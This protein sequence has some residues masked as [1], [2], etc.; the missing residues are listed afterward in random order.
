MAAAQKVMII[1]S[2]GYAVGVTSQGELKV[3]LTL[4]G[5]ITSYSYAYATAANPSYTEATLNPLSVNL[6]GQLR[7]TLMNSSGTTAFGT[8]GSSSAAVLTVQGIASGTALPVS[9]S[10]STS[11]TMA[12]T[13]VTVPATANG[14]SVLASNSSRK[15][16]VITNL[17]PTTVFLAQTNALTTTTAIAVAAGASFVVDS[18]LYTGAFFGITASG[19]QVVSVAEFT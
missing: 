9:V 19:T 11:S 7:T 17:G 2:D 16:A 8:A 3:D 13:Q 4:S 1:G 15:G 14:I 12:T 10:A 6:T 18:P 5:P